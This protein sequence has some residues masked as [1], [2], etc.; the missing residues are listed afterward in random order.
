MEFCVGMH[1]QHLLLKSSKM[2][3][4]GPDE[5]FLIQPKGI[6]SHQKVKVQRLDPRNFISC[7]S[8]SPFSEARGKK[9]VTLSKFNSNS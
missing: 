5:N 4:I 1:F 6:M 9:K 3:Y 2:F 8:T 7:T